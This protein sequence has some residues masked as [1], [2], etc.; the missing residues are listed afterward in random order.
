M[1]ISFLKNALKQRLNLDVS[2]IKNIAFI[3]ENI[4]ELIL[5]E[6][7]L[8][9]ISSKLEILN[10]K[11]TEFKPFAEN[12]IKNTFERLKSISDR[13]KNKFAS[14]YK[15]CET[16]L[17]ENSE[18]FSKDVER[19]NICLPKKTKNSIKK[20]SIYFISIGYLNCNGLNLNT[21]NNIFYDNY[22]RSL[23]IICLVETFTDI[24]FLNIHN[25][26]LIFFKK[27]VN[28]RSCNKKGEGMCIYAKKNLNFTDVK[29][30]VFG[31]SLT[32]RNYSLLFFYISPSLKDVKSYIRY[33]EPIKGK[34][35][36]LIGDMN[37]G[38]SHDRRECID[39]FASLSLM[40]NKKFKGKTFK[41]GNKN[42][43]TEKVYSNCK[44]DI[45]VQH[46][47]SSDHNLVIVTHAYSY[48]NRFIFDFKLL[49][50]INVITK[51]RNFLDSKKSYLL[52]KNKDISFSNI[53]SIIKS[54]M[55]FIRRKIN[56][57]RDVIYSYKNLWFLSKNYNSLKL[58]VNSNILKNLLPTQIPSRLVKLG[59][60]CHS[61][62]PLITFIELQ[63]TIDSLK[64]GK[65]GG[66]NCIRYELLKIVQDYI[67]NCIVIIFNRIIK[68]A[69]IPKEW[70]KII[71]RPIPKIGN[72]IRPISL[73][74]VFRKVFE[75]L[76]LKRI[77]LKL[78]DNQIGFKE[79]NRRED[80][81]LFFDDFLK[82]SNGV[83]FSVTLDISKAFDS[84]NRQLLYKKLIK[85]HNVSSKMLKIITA[86]I[87]NN[88]YST[89]STPNYDSWND[90]LLGLPQGSIL[91]PLL[92]NVFIDNLM[93][94]VPTN[95][96]SNILLYADDILIFT[97]SYKE[98]QD[99]IEIVEKHAILNDYCLNP[100]KSFAMS[101]DNNDKKF[102]LKNQIIKNVAILKY[103]GH[104]FN[105]KGIDL[106]S[107]INN[108][109]KLV[110]INVLRIKKNVKLKN[111]DKISLML[112]EY[113]TFILPHIDNLLIV[114][115]NKKTAIDKLE[116]IQKK[117][118]KQI[119]LLPF[120]LP[121]TILYALI[122]II[123]ITQRSELLT[124]NYYNSLK[125]STK[126]HFA[127]QF[128]KKTPKT[129]IINKFI[130]CSALWPNLKNSEI[131]RH[132]SNLARV[133]T[134]SVPNAFFKGLVFEKFKKILMFFEA[135][136]DNSKVL[137]QDGL[138]HGLTELI[139]KIIKK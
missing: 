49:N 55:K 117:T 101:N 46:F 115:C 37:F 38:N 107:S 58:P 33:I 66:L 118:I 73:T 68:K 135:S 114:L 29:E 48:L 134:L 79:K 104:Y 8:T 86:L 16:T 65:C 10:I 43:Q 99:L 129:K 98:S 106:N 122:P 84:V 97:K 85:N 67:L 54:S 126:R 42:S 47:H 13:T 23:D 1:K 4:T 91:S 25:W 92:F 94:L 75:K 95:Y 77:N 51:I 71:I 24:Y 7:K 127:K 64:S 111:R 133:Y 19:G 41:H 62:V 60:K 102:K 89:D 27:T 125:Q 103:L 35:R 138:V 40:K 109:R 52:C 70:K 116:R 93:N 56:I 63:N 113:K 83:S 76:L 22:N 3:N 14:L 120:R 28:I 108:C 88:K 39:N 130:Q 81:I 57:T 50:D 137:D 132:L 96:K 36:I 45:Y 74:D 136:V 105:L 9:E 131:Q 87:E 11:L 78:A 139:L 59:A 2:E 61:K 124:R 32:Y 119:F 20:N 12:N 30:N 82:R 15:F 44:L 5:N 72:K 112:N 21:L 34:F 123:P 53:E 128:L 17:S 110:I 80:H 90:L 6:S 18:K 121:T 100:K 69:K 26:K 31:C